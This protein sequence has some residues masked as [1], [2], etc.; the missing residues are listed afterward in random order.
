M[1]FSIEPSFQESSASVPVLLLLSAG[2]DPMASLLAFAD[3]KQARCEA[4]SL[5]RG[6]GPIA[7][8]LVSSGAKEGFWVVRADL[9]PIVRSRLS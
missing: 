7:K 9:Q 3:E 2:A 4:V 6:Q 5:G 8:R 1:P